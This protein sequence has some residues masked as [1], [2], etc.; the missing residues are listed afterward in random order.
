MCA[1]MF[2]CSTRYK[3]TVEGQSIYQQ[4]IRRYCVNQ[5]KAVFEGQRTSRGTKT[6]IYPKTVASQQT[7]RLTFL[8]SIKVESIALEA[9]HETLHASLFKAGPDLQ[10][11]LNT[12]QLFQNQAQEEVSDPSVIRLAI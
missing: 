2:F 5:T 4:N 6:S 10:L 12:E 7:F 11:A 8:P 9:I 1:F 3:R